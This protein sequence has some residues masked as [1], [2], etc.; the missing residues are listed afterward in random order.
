MLKFCAPEKPEA[1]LLMRQKTD[2][3]EMV[4]RRA[5]LQNIQSPV[6]F[7]AFAGFK[8]MYMRNFF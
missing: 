4:L 3:K 6:S 8:I 2:I 5:K 7:R 1:V